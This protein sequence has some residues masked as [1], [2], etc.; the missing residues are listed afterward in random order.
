MRL[1]F[2]K[3]SGKYDRLEVTRSSGTSEVIECPKQRIIPHDMVHF[4]VERT[5]DARGFLRRID[6]GE[7]AI[8][9]MKEEK[10]SDG[11]ERLVE[12]IQGDEWSGG[13][14]TPEDILDLYEVNCRAKN[15]AALA[16]NGDAVLA[17][18]A[19]IARLTQLWSAV[20]VGGSVD[21]EFQ[22]S[23]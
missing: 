20:P 13:H 6:D 2:T 8:M 12:V 19:E 14:S 23:R 5:L 4:A 15:C 21:L 18:R 11:V 17:I 16:V 7:A 3:G 22:G 9:Q 1:R 10:Q